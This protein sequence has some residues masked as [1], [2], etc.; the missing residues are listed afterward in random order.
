MV[1]LQIQALIFSRSYL[2]CQVLGLK[3]SDPWC[4]GFE[5]PFLLPSKP[6]AHFLAATG[7]SFGPSQVSN[8]DS[9]RELLSQGPLPA[10]ACTQLPSQEGP[11][12]AHTMNKAGWPGPE[13]SKALPQPRKE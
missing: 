3:F 5:R 13:R 10:R 2:P 8:Q 1:N 6:A 9:R 12:R 4:L 11:A 7:F